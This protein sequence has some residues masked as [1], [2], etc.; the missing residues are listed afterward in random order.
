MIRTVVLCLLVSGVL[1]NASFGFAQEA[2]PV[3]EDVVKELQFFVG[4]WKAEGT[5]VDSKLDARFSASWEPGKHCVLVRYAGTIGYTP[6]YATELYGWDNSAK[7]I[8]V[9]SFFSHGVLEDIRYKRVS[10]AKYTGT[11]KGSAWGEPFEAECSIEKDGP[12]KW[13]F[14]ATNLVAAGKKRPEIQVCFKRI[15]E[16][17]DAGE[18]AFRKWA[19]VVVGGTWNGV[20]EDGKAVQERYRW[21][22]GKRYLQ[23][24]ASGGEEG[25]VIAVIGIDP[26]T[27][28]CT[29]W[30]F[31]SLG[32]VAKGTMSL[33]EDG[34]WQYYGEG[35]GVRG[36]GS[37]SCEPTLIDKDTLKENRRTEVIEG[38]A[39]E[40]PPI[41]WK[42]HVEER[43][44]RQQ[45]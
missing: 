21:I 12:D 22:L 10:E 31:D 20:N 30:G 1:F 25:D 41:V 39:K 3:P 44:G 4:D 43:Q 32:F 16:S 9:T 37:Y 15:T 24:N 8:T 27:R 19:D 36:K 45:R 28:K 17:A 13:A 35:V 40:L 14:R 29:W 5:T 34:V 2:M 38:V 7:A 23:Y 18:Q 6:F 33:R 11:Y 42:R 26:E